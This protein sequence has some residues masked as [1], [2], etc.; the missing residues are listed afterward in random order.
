[1]TLQ[2]SKIFRLVLFKR[3]ITEQVVGP[4]W[5]RQSG[6]RAGRV[7]LVLFKIIEQDQEQA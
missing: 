1:M 6:A 7:F 4:D 2:K 5:Q 3:R